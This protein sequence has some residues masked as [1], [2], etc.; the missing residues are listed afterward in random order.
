MHFGR[1]TR[2]PNLHGLVVGNIETRLS[3]AVFKLAICL[4]W[5]SSM[6]N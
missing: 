5:D 2:S 6:T 3:P 4:I 1:E